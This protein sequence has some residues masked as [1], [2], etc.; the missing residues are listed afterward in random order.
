MAR[1]LP[2][3]G[4]QVEHEFFSESLVSE[5]LTLEFRPDKTSAAMMQR[6]NLL[7]RRCDRGIEIW[8]EKRETEQTETQNSDEVIA[9][10]DFVFLVSSP[11][12][13]FDFYTAWGL[14][15]PIVF[16]RGSTDLNAV[17][18]A[19]TQSLQMQTATTSD[20]GL[21]SFERQRAALVFSVKLEHKLQHSVSAEMTCYVIHLKARPLHWK[22]YFCGALAKKQLQI[23][24]LDRENDGAGTLFRPSP[25]VAGSNGQAYISDTALP[26]RSIPSQRFQLREADATGRVLI[27][28]MPNASIQKI[29]KE[30][31]PDG[32][33]L[34][35]AEIYIHQ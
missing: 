14:A 15:K 28:R 31:G 11:D 26:M 35:V 25:N 8:Q 33:S 29:G 7:L 18:Q 20:D 10:L 34:V 22:Y 12:P 19:T 4:L 1:Y 23:V 2:L 32:Q 3:F 21:S 30:V 17:D 24:D 13:M 27:R 9:P 16:C 6:E 5:S